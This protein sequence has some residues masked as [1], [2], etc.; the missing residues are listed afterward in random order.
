MYGNDAFLDE[1]REGTG[2]SRSEYLLNMVFPDK[3]DGLGPAY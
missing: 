3:T 2:L 1:F